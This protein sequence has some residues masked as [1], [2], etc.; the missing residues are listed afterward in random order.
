MTAHAGFAPRVVLHPDFDSMYSIRK[1][2]LSFNQIDIQPTAERLAEIR[3][4]GADLDLVNS[5]ISLDPRVPEFQL[6]DYGFDSRIDPDFKRFIL[7]TNDSLSSNPDNMRFSVGRS[8]AL[9]DGN[10]SGASSGIPTGGES[11]A[12]LTQREGEYNFYEMA[13]EWKAASAGDLDFS[14]TSGLT[15]IQANVSKQ[16]STGDSYKIYDVTNRVVAVPTIG[17][18]VRW[19]IS[20]DWSLSGQATTQSLNMGSSLV[21]FNA[22]SDWKITDR[23]GLSAGYQILRSEFDLGAVT[24]D[25]NQEGLFARFHI[26][27]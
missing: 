11:I 23:I 3:A 10:I 25:L 17:S 9:N 4:M 1:P 7:N 20:Q 18:A 19:N 12:S 6:A 8:T 26:R 5:T 16:V 21:G 13:V 14:I 27:F 15:A 24:T 22:Q 2:S